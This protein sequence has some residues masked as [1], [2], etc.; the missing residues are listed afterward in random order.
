MSTP[1]PARRR[2]YRWGLGAET[3]AAVA[4][5]LKAYR[6]LGRRVRTGAG[7]IDLVA[8]RGT[9][10]AIVEVKARTTEAAALEAVGPRTQARL[11]RAAAVWLS[12]NPR[13][14]DH[15]IR[16]D[17]VAVVPGRWPIHVANAFAARS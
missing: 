3:R 9:T 14:A 2:A 7:E 1:A 12:Q 5:T 13:Y 10:I 15:T 16:F 6:I 11:V 4:L 17:I 8:K